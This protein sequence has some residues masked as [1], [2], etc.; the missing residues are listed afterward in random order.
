M[1]WFIL[2]EEHRVPRALGASQSS[3]FISKRKIINQVSAKGD[4]QEQKQANLQS[5]ALRGAILVSTRE[6]EREKTQFF[7]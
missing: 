3:I 2:F 1:T 6:S 4:E 7:K 5:A